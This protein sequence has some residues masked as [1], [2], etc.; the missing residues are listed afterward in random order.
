MKELWVDAWDKCYHRAIDELGMS[1]DEAGQYADNKADETFREHFADRIDFARML[2]KE[3][4][5]T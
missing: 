2:A 4:K 1:D 3:G 5:L